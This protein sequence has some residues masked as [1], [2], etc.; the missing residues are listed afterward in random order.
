MDKVK[1][2]KTVSVR[3]CSQYKESE[4]LLRLSQELATCFHIEPD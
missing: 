3:N 1:E 4:G 2:K